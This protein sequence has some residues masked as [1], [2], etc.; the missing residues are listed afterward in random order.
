ML[1]VGAK[2]SKTQKLFPSFHFILL[3]ISR[4]HELDTYSHT[5]DVTILFLSLS[6]YSGRLPAVLQKSA[7][8]DRACDTF[9]VVKGDPRVD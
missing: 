5:N 4:V 1:G 9:A 8:K 7:R 2:A 3:F 6:W